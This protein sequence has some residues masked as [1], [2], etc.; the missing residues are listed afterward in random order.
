MDTLP[1][2]QHRGETYSPCVGLTTNALPDQKDSQAGVSVRYA[3]N[4]KYDWYVLRASYG[5]EKK[6]YDH[7]T[8]DGFVAYLPYHIVMISQNGMKRKVKK[9][10][11]PNMLFVY[12]N[13]EQIEKYI[14]RTPSLSFLKFYYNRLTTNI[15]GT[16]P[17]LTVKYQDMMNFIEITSV[18]NAHIKVVKNSQCYFKCDDIVR[19]KEGSFKGIEGRVARVLGQQRVV[20]TIDGL[21]TIATAYIPSAFLEIIK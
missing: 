18:E 9:H 16:N 21:C 14:K 4:P 5:R 7:V 2:V 20:V 3:H 11:L 6:A 15:D 17:P 19:I 10:L 1:N 8:H 12:S 13:K